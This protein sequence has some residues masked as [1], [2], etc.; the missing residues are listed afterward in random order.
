MKKFLTLALTLV[1]VFALAIPVMAWTGIGN[2][3]RV[4]TIAD[5]VVVVVTSDDYNVPS[6][7]LTISEDAALGQ[8]ELRH[9]QSGDILFDARTDVAVGPVT[10][11]PFAQGTVQYV[12]TPDAVV[13]LD[14]S[15]LS[16]AI[17][18]WNE[19]YRDRYTVNSLYVL[20]YAFI[21]GWNIYYANPYRVNATQE[22][23]N[24]KADAILDAIY[25]LETRG[26]LL[27]RIEHADITAGL[28]LTGNVLTLTFEG[29]V[30]TLSTTANNMNQSGSIDIGGGYTL[31]F[32]IRGNGTNISYFSVVRN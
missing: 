23:I 20:D 28:S 15:R 25:D 30:F 14:W 10:F 18:R 32:D 31:I 6:F 8:L 3:N 22:E 2:G 17:Q 26:A 19:I 9:S 13:E 11:G 24:A 4:F 16:Y 1:M 27:G 7:T 29:N 12:W 5:G 21:A